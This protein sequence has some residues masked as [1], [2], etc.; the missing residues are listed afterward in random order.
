MTF[1]VATR[2]IFLSYRIDYWR[3]KQK[4]NKNN[5]D[6]KSARMTKAPQRRK[7]F[8]VVVKK[9]VVYKFLL[10]FLGEKKKNQIK[11]GN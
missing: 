5:N 3:S 1:A 2:I 7:H 9:R 6:E 10:C 11:Q 4:K 8:F